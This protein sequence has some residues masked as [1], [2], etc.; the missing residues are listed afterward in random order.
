MNST[1]RNYLMTLYLQVVKFK[2]LSLA[3]EDFNSGLSIV[4]S[5][6]PHYVITAFSPPQH[7]PC[8][9]CPKILTISQTSSVLFQTPISVPEMLPPTICTWNPYSNVNLPKPLGRI[10]YCLCIYLVLCVPVLSTQWVSNLG[11]PVRAK[12]TRVSRKRRNSVLA[13]I[14]FTWRIQRLRV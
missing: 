7:I 13:V 10:I 4:S 2:L 9:E 11:C 5:L 3:S 6:F 1:A 12:N 14:E 8:S